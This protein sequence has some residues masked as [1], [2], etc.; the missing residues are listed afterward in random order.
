MNSHKSFLLIL[1]LTV[2]V[3]GNASVQGSLPG[4]FSVGEHK[5]AVFSQGNMQ[6]NAAQ[7]SHQCYL[8]DTLVP[9]TWRFAPHQYDTIGKANLNS[10]ATYSGW[11]DLFSWGTSGKS[12]QPYTYTDDMR[13]K[14]R[15]SGLGYY[16]DWA[17]YN[18][19]SNGGN[20]PRLW[21]TPTCEEMAYVLVY[22]E[23][24]QYLRGLGQING[25]NGYIILPDDWQ[26]PDGLTFRPSKLPSS[27]TD[28]V[29]SLAQWEQMQANGAVFFPMAGTAS[30]TYSGSNTKMEMYTNTTTS[31]VY[32]STTYYEPYRLLISADTLHMGCAY[33]STYTGGGTRRSVRPIR[34]TTVYKATFRGHRDGEENQLLD[35]Q[36]L[37]MSEVPTAPSVP[38]KPHYQFLRWDKPIDSIKNDIVYN[39]VYVYV[40]DNDT[41]EIQGSLNGIFSV[42]ETNQIAFSR[43]NL[44]YN[45]KLDSALCL[46][47]KKHVGTWRFAENQ[48]DF[49]GDATYGNVYWND[50]KCDNTLAQYKYTGW[51][52]MFGW[53]ATGYGNYPYNIRAYRD[54]NKLDVRYDVWYDWGKFNPISNGMNL[55]DIWYTLSKEEWNYLLFKRPH[56]DSLQGMAVIGPIHGFV[57]LPDDWQLPEGLTFSPASQDSVINLYS[58]ANWRRME[59]RGAVFIPFSGERTSKEFKYSKTISRLW[60]STFYNYNSSMTS[61]S[62]YVASF[63]YKSGW[64]SY[65]SV[66]T[67]YVG[68][69]PTYYAL[70]VRLAI[71]TSPVH[72]VFRGWQDGEM[73]AVLFERDFARGT[74]PI[75]SVAPESY[76]MGDSVYTFVGWSPELQPAYSDAVYTARYFARLKT[77]GM[78]NLLDY[79]NPSASK[80]IQEGQLIILLNGKMYNALG[81]EITNP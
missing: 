76:E 10:S 77:E 17:Q 41:V 57:L 54:V 25:I 40:P 8:C 12:A 71:P 14:A 33:G 69:S 1:F 43:G 59:E 73:D 37:G 11:I 72:V 20:Q 24:A 13:S 22:R 53:G 7:G 9:G 81:G 39:A 26:L 21:R 16:Y 55:P 64:S 65:N 48:Y 63:S 46:D 18:A 5:R 50:V 74:I 19:I 66:Y 67:Q 34:D 58:Y 51:I 31:R 35:L 62:A 78:E 2:S 15:I 75:S 3:V 30:Y 29:Y 80:V 52:D 45:A 49:V 28:N 6:Y 27:F 42:S 23:N 44:Q 79:L 56:A 32:N 47:G 36:L 60:T 68:A 38:D 70:S 61:L 4:L